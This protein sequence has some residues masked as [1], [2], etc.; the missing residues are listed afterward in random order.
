MDP[1]S[2]PITSLRDEPPR[3]GATD[4]KPKDG[5]SHIQ[6]PSEPGLVR[7]TIG[8]LLDDTAMRFGGRLAAA[9]PEFGLR[10]SYNDLAEESRKLAGGLLAL[11]LKKGD[12]VGIWAPNRPEWIAIQYA[13]ARVGIILVNINPAYRTAELKHALK[14]A[15][16]KVL[17]T[18]ESFKS[19]DY[20]KMLKEI[21]PELENHGSGA[22]NIAALP[23]L[24]HCVRLGDGEIPGMMN[25]SDVLDL[26][27]PSSMTEVDRIAAT[28]DPDDPINI[29]FTS[30][31]TGSPKGATLTHHN[32]VNNGRFTVDRLNLK[33][34]EKL[35]IPVP[36]YHCFG[37]V[38]GSLGCV[39]TGSAMVFPGEGFDAEQT[40]AAISSERCAAVYGVATMFVAMLESPGFKDHDLSCL[41]TGIMAGGPCPI[42]LMKRVVTEMHMSEVTIAYGMTETSPV[43]FQS[44]VDDPFEARVSTAGRIHP[45]VEA[46]VV[47]GGGQVCPVGVQGEICIR[48]YSVMRGYW[49]DAERTAES[50]D[51]SGWMHTGDLGTFDEEGYCSITGRV[52]D[53]VIRGG[54]N[55]YPREIEEFLF[56]HPDVLGVQV[57]GVPDPKFTEELCA[58]VVLRDGASLTEDGLR[59]YCEGQIAHYKIPRHIRFKDELP[60]TISGKPQKFKMRD[61]MVKELGLT[62]A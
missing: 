8:Q 7:Q 48:G 20:I 38:M 27:G 29:Q 58:W 51:A 54:E 32:I 3:D 6:G 10:W 18:A 30:G 5:L 15:G 35:C 39:S 45:H 34:D 21:A 53:M 43:S 60:M 2:T 56:A 59:D 31:T 12:R 19:S 26:A 17:V 50:V 49:G 52:K 61:E 22:L 36:L 47:D 1:L 11:G 4:L 40:L 13:T 33:P 42:E 14:A 25:Y 41:R 55:I 44:H 23:D 9:F 62:E 28:L 16:I 24:D 37:M 46:K 57:F